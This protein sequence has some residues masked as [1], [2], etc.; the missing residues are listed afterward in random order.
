VL[1]SSASQTDCLFSQHRN[2]FNQIK[3]LARFPVRL[4]GLVTPESPQRQKWG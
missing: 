1:D 2:D 3:E 4:A